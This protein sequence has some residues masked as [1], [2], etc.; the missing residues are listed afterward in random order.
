[1]ACNAMVVLK[2]K[3][4]IESVDRTKYPID[5]PVLI[6]NLVTITIDKQNVATF[7]YT[8]NSWDQGVTLLSSAVR[9]M[10]TSGITFDNIG[11]PETHVHANHTQSIATYH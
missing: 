11:T 9:Y 3:V 2:A 6:G 4:K 10:T 7:K 5:K 8:G 1:M